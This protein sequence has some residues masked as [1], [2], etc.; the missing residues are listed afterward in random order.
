MKKI[1][2]FGMFVLPAFLSGCS[3]I[4]TIF[5]GGMWFG[6][7]LVVAVIGLLVFFLTRTKK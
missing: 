6:I 1:H 3:A 5:K 2:L 4:G 7:F